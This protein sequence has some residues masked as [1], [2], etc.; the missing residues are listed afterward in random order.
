MTVLE[1][2]CLSTAMSMCAVSARSA[3]RGVTCVGCGP[4]PRPDTR[5]PLDFEL[6]WTLEL[7]LR[8]VRHT[9]GEEGHALLD[10]FYRKIHMVY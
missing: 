3:D 1:T 2:L 6:N 10:D 8:P 7:E 5:L 4:D 9:T